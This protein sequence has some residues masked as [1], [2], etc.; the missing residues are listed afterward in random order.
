MMQGFFA[1]LSR[2][3]PPAE[4]Y[5]S[6]P[7]WCYFLVVVLVFRAVPARG[8][9]REALLLA[10]NVL[11]LLSLPRF[12]GGA[13]LLYFGLALWTFAI[14][15][16]LNRG[17]LVNTRA[18]I[19]TAG[20]GILGVLLVLITFK[21]R[22]VQ[23][24]LFGGKGLL[25][26]EPSDFVFLIGIS[27]SSFKAIHFVVESYKKGV[28][29]L[30]FL[31]FINY[32]LFFPAFVSGPINRYNDFLETSA[33]AQQSRFRPDF[34]A[35]F[36]R[37]VH[38]LFKKFVLTQILFPYTLV[39]SSTPLAEM[40][41]WQIVLGIYA[42]A[43][44]FYFDFSGY[45]DLAIGSARLLGYN[46]PENF[47]FP[48]LKKNIQ[49]LWANWHMSL[50]SWLTDYVYW[51][52]VRLMRKSDSLRKYPLLISNAAIITT[53]FLCGIWHGETINFIL[54][55]LYHGVGIA[56]VNVYQKWK[57]QVRTPLALK[58]F[59]SP[60]SYGLG[61]VVTFNFF[62]LGLLF[63]LNAEQARTVFSR[64]VTF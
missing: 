54:W 25:G 64:F 2:W 12:S 27:Y 31:T 4:F 11:M 41:P 57:R 29:D 26:G 53:F 62:S 14:G 35:G 49:Q 22:F 45:S 1:D 9:A 13:L 61:V 43:L 33:R 58:Y 8:L 19:A 34:A 32:I 16:S 15:S 44:F 21:Y 63:M 39:H 23:A 51:P 24:G 18:R 10:A 55:G 30:R 37:I 5:S 52:L 40:Q 17:T 3:L 38:G 48:F 42:Y 6:A 7:F 56:A 47:N 59:S 20:L 60:L 36:E 46:L 28:K 50:T